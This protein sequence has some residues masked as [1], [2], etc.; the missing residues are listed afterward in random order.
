LIHPK[1]EDRPAK[2][3]RKLVAQRGAQSVVDV[4]GH[5]CSFVVVVV[6]RENARDVEHDQLDPRKSVVITTVTGA[7]A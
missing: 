6:T 4:L 3:Q 2:Q 1:Q 7:S 5:V